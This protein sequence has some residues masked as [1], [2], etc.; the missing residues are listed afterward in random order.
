[1]LCWKQVLRILVLLPSRFNLSGPRF[2]Y[3]KLHFCSF[4]VRRC[5]C[6]SSP[7]R[8]S[9]GNGAVQAVRNLTDNDLSTFGTH[10][11]NGSL[12]FVVDKQT[13]WV[14]ATRSGSSTTSTVRMQGGTGKPLYLHMTSTPG[15][16]DDGAGQQA[17]VTRGNPDN[18]KADRQSNFGLYAYAYTGTF[19]ADD[20]RF[21]WPI[22][23]AEMDVNPQ[24]R[25]Q[26]NP[27]Y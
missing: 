21:T 20:Y 3:S 27:G 1:M 22:P 19:S 14:P 11:N 24:L 8:S 4:F 23:Q 10:P 25:G 16:A 17:P 26:Q 18:E 6:I 13:E 9:S 5:H 15:I 2:S 12:N 7:S